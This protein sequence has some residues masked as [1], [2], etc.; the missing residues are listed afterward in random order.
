MDYRLEPA[1]PTFRRLV[2][3]LDQV[4]T[5]FGFTEG[6]VWRGEDLLFSDIPRSRTIRYRPLPEGAEITTFRHPTGNA[7]G[8]TLDR[9]GRLLTCEHSGRK[10]S[11]I[12]P[13]GE[14][15][16]VAYSYQ[17][18]RFNSPND[19]VVR[20]DGS[21]YFTDPSYGLP[22]HSVGR[23]IP[24][25]GVYRVDPT[26]AVHLLVSD[27]ELPNGLA[28]A[29]GERTLFVDDSGRHHIRAFDVEADG[30]I[31]NGRIWAEMKPKP[32][33]TDVPDGMKVDVEGNV[34]CTAAGGVWIFDANARVL[35]RIILPE[36][37]ANLGWG[38]SDWRTLYLT[39][40]TSLYRLRMHVPGL[41]VGP[42]ARKA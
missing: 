28:F 23:E 34:Y 24:H 1:Y 5:G 11:R 15:V 40:K 33:E 27:F 22:N 37:P 35:G 20:S 16:T 9:Q 39:A 36:V 19:V 29:P 6:P 41:P 21:I 25:N 2:P 14:V 17:G 12:D 7:N 3:M 42:A 4:A 13:N 32:G 30:S 8:M 10:V 18:K 26:G 38:G 31:S